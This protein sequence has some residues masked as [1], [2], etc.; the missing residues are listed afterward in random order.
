MKTNTNLERSFFLPFCS[1]KI[2]TE[3]P[4]WAARKRQGDYNLRRD[5]DASKYTFIYCI[6][7]H[8]DF[9]RVYTQVCKNF[10]WWFCVLR[11]GILQSRWGGNWCKSSCSAGAEVRVQGPCLCPWPADCPHWAWEVAGTLARHTPGAWGAAGCLRSSFCCWPSRGRELKQ[12]AAG[13]QEAGA[14]ETVTGVSMAHNQS[15]ILL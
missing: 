2:I 12:S 8:N 15:S 1:F 4:S 5:E 13:G 10:T 7:F 6:T 3:S 9:N 11:G 14:D